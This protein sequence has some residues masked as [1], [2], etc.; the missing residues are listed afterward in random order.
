MICPVEIARET[1]AFQAVKV[2]DHAK[3]GLLPRAAMERVMKV[4]EV[5]LRAM[6]RKIWATSLVICRP[7]PALYRLAKS[8]DK[9]RSS[10]KIK[11]F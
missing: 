9:D 7:A 10:A 1:S 4:Q 5:I 6:A 2:D 11:R 8:P 3:H